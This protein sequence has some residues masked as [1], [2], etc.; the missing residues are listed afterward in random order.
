MAEDIFQVPSDLSLITSDEDLAKLLSDATKEF[1]RLQAKDVTPEALQYQMRLTDDIGRIRAE[2]TGRAA[3]AAQEAEQ[4]REQMLQQRDTLLARIHGTGTA[5]DGGEVL[6]V[7]HPGGM[8][9]DQ[10]AQVAEAAARGS[11]AALIAALGDRG[12]RLNQATV[13]AAGYSVSV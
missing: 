3:R 1:D 12:G 10:L 7:G 6:P 8:S 9:T 5:S 2:Q 13:V 11:T 4:A